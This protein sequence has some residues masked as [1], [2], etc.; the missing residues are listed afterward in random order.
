MIEIKLKGYFIVFEGIDCVGKSTIMRLVAE[1]LRELGYNVYITSEPS[2]SPIGKLIRDWLLKEHVKPEHIYALL[3]TA[4][5]YYHYFNEIK[6]YLDQGYI[7][8]CERYIDSTIVYQMIQGIDRLWIEELNRYIPKPNLVILLD[9]PLETVIE[10][11]SSRRKVEI[12]EKDIQFLR[13]VREIYLEIAREKN[14][15]IVNTARDIYEIV[16]EIIEIIKFRLGI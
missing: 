1:K 3:F 16:N 7:V 6:Y 13:R 4:D 8:L 5:R 9:A 15:P 11:L 2:N 12:F 10:R 14:Y